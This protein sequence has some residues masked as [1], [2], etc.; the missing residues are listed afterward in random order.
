MQFLERLRASSGSEP[1]ESVTAF[2]VGLALLHESRARRFS[3]TRMALAST[4][5]L[6]AVIRLAESAVRAGVLVTVFEV[7]CARCGDLVKTTPDDPVGQ[8][9][10]CRDPSCS[11]EFEI[12][13]AHVH[14]LYDFGDGFE[15]PGG[16]SPG[17]ASRG[18]P[19]LK[20]MP[21]RPTQTGSPNNARP[22]NPPMNSVRLSTRH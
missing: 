20:R 19:E 2:A 16:D 7:D 14:V 6:D 13:V 12:R 22:S 17:G 11:A 3:P 8:V 5:E 10:V 4:L 21:R 1:D 15:P 9:A 18:S